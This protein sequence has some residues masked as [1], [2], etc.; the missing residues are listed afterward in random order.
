MARQVAH[1]DTLAVSRDLE[2]A[3]LDRRR[4]D[5]IAAQMASAVAAGHPEAA[6]KA[7]LAKFQSRMGAIAVGMVLAQTVLIFGLLKVVA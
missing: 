1:F 7:D 3:G 2:A 5:A 6:T 4:A